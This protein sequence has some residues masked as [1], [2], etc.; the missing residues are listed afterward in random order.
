MHRWRWLV[1]RR[2][3]MGQFSSLVSAQLICLLKNIVFI[4]SLYRY[5]YIVSPLGREDDEEEDDE[6]GDDGDDGKVLQCSRLSVPCYLPTR[7]SLLYSLF[8]L[9]HF[10]CRKVVIVQL[11]MCLMR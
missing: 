9:L 5:I 10:N 7:H 3:G 1:A 4:V 11:T 2:P 8:L 6:D